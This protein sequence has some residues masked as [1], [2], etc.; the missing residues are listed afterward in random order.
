MSSGLQKMSKDNMDS[1]SGGVSG[2]IIEDANLKYDSYG[3]GRKDG[4]STRTL[5][6]GTAV[7]FDRI[8]DKPKSGQTHSV[9]VKD[10]GWISPDQIELT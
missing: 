4:K 9:H 7:E 2:R 1:V 10:L 5:K 8:L 3:S 6:A